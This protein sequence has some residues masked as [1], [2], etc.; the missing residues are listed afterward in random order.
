MNLMGVTSSVGVKSLDFGQIAIEHD[1]DPPRLI[2]N[3]GKG[4]FPHRAEQDQPSRNKH[5]LAVARRGL[6]VM[7]R[8]FAFCFQNDLRRSLRVDI[9]RGIGFDSQ[10][11]DF[12]QLAAPV[13]ELFVMMI[14]WYGKRHLVYNLSSFTLKCNMLLCCITQPTLSDA[15]AEMELSRPYAQGFE[16]RL[17]L[18]Q[19]H[20]KLGRLAA[21]ARLPLLFTLKN[22]PPL[23]LLSLAAYCDLPLDTDPST[24]LQIRQKFPALHLI[25]SHH[26]FQE[27]PPLRFL[28]PS[29][30]HSYKLAYKANS[31]LDMLRL[32]LFKKN[33]PLPLTAISLGE[34]GRASRLLAPLVGNLFHYAST[35]EDAELGRYSLE[36]LEKIFHFSRLNRETEIFGLIG[37][38]IDASIGHLFHNAAFA[39]Q[40]RNAVYIKMALKKEELSAFFSLAAQLPI[41]GLSVTMPLKEAVDPLFQCLWRPQYPRSPRENRDQYRRPC[42][43]QCRRAPFP[44]P[45]QTDRSPRRR[46]RGPRHRPRSTSTRRPRHDLQPHSRKSP[47][48]RRSSRLF[49]CQ[50]K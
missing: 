19:E 14:F 38:P 31:T 45:R 17:D 35:Q 33:S 37:D 43:S 4:I 12:R 29:F 16:I 6:V 20:S 49:C 13:D 1:L 22:V 27:T 8:L 26:N 25:G 18:F 50:L 47:K 7:G 11:A 44:R 42:R 36:N 39:E 24:L 15:L 32:M 30:F 5:M 34:Y 9:F 41:R 40:K 28:P 2:L 10:S 21:A 23:E 3:V 48:A 46:R